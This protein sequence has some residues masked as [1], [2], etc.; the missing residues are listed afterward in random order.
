MERKIGEE[1]EYNGV[2]LKVVEYKASDGKCCRGCFFS[3]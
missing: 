3:P 2:K 1:F